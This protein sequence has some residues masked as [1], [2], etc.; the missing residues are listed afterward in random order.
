MVHT[1]GVIGFRIGCRGWCIE[2]EKKGVSV[3][4]C[5]CCVMVAVTVVKMVAASQTW[6]IMQTAAAVV[7]VVAH[8]VHVGGPNASGMLCL[9]LTL[10]CMYAAQGCV[11]CE[12]D[13]LTH[14]KVP[15]P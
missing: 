15:D 12:A 13:R 6:C 1:K 3:V 7:V 8:G 11:T 4:P 2:R 5:G 10:S 14:R 9:W